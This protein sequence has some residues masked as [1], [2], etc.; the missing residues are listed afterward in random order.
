M[1]QSAAAN[2]ALTKVGFN[3]RPLRFAYFVLEDDRQGFER[4]VRFTCTQWGGIRNFIIPVPSD[5]QLYPLCE[6]LLRIHVPDRFVSYLPV[7]ADTSGL[8]GRLCQLFP[9]SNVRL[10]NG[11]QWEERDRSM[12]PLSV[13]PHD[14]RIPPTSGQ[15]GGRQSLLTH[16]LPDGGAD[17]L[18][19]LTLFGALHPGQEEEYQKAFTLVPAPVS[20]QDESFW[21][22]QHDSTPF[23]S[24][25]N[26]TGYNLQTHEIRSPSNDLAFHVL[27]TDSVR[28]LCLFWN[29]RALNEATKTF[30]QDGRRTFL[31]PAHRIADPGIAEGLCRFI[32]S[33]PAV[34]N[35]S[36]ELDIFVTCTEEETQAAFQ[37]RLEELQGNEIL[38]QARVGVSRWSGYPDRVPREA[39]PTRVLRCLFARPP[40]CSSF[41]EGFGR[42]PLP[43]KVFLSQ[44]KNEILF[45]PPEGFSNHWSGS[46]AVDFIC[47]AWKDYPRDPAVARLVTQGA[48]FSPYGLSVELDTPARPTYLDVTIPPP[49]EALRAYFSRRGY[50][51]RIS[52]PGQYANALLGLVGGLKGAEV[53]AS[54]L[55]YRLL[56]AL[57]V[58]SSKK[59]AQR[60]SKEL[61]LAEATEEDLIR[62]LRDAD[63]V[64]ELKKVPKTFQ[65]LRGLG[66]KRSLIELLGRL[67]AARVVKRGFHATCPE[68]Q[69]P[70]WFPL[71][72]IQEY[73]TCPGCSAVFLLPVEHPPKSGLEV[74]WEYTLNSLVNR[75]MDQDVL[76]AVLAL[77]HE[78]KP[79][80]DSFFVPGLELVPNGKSDPEAEFDFFFIREQGLFAGEC[81]AG[82]EL[83]DK[84]V[85]TGLLAADLGVKEFSFCTVRKFSTA[86]LNL[87]E[88]LRS[89]VA[90]RS[91]EMTVKVLTGDDLLGGALP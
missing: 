61:K 10:L 68:C 74:A 32:R 45:D 70:A 75:V 3:V 38:T 54:S 50:E 47:D 41:T 12:H 22:L 65:E 35:A 64:S 46:T 72:A 4:I 79:Q 43:A 9:G 57:A 18:H 23:G 20:P 11:P 82:T 67:A 59:V 37:R 39:D 51:A 15:L 24:V 36:S 78:T 19:L 81:K 80:G 33:V 14:L 27:V 77:Y 91:K 56:D 83:A 71:H 48:W 26:V 6:Q 1:A 87:V 69:T 85:R 55:T 86:A 53:F 88:Q 84:D 25:L 7:D 44:G 73:L 29:Y 58:K 49:W 60:I 40:V 13:I 34:P 66:E 63:V 21:K 62:V 30:V 2:P 28:D 5:L 90:Q 8:A 16:L 76:P 52:P 31:V 17:N 42:R 89:E